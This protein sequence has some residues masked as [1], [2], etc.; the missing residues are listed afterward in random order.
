LSEIQGGRLCGAPDLTRRA[1]FRKYIK[2][3]LAIIGRET[4]SLVARG[5]EILAD[6]RAS[7]LSLFI[8]PY[9]Q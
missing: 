2:L 9:A 6:P 5:R 7:R 3:L 8:I 4:K 1:T